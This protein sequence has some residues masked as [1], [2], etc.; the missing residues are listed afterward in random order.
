MT[1]LVFRIS[2]TILALSLSQV[3]FAEGS[4]PIKPITMIVGFAAGGPTDQAARIVAQ[5]MESVLQKPIVIENKPGANSTLS[6][7]ALQAS[8]PDGYTILIASNGILTV[9]GARYKNI[10]FDVSKDL[11][12]IG[13]VAGY[14]HVLV[15][16]ENSK[17]NDVKSII[18]SADV[19]YPAISSVGNVDELTIALFQN[20]TNKK[21]NSIPYKGQAAVIPDLI[22]N[23]VNMAFLAPNVAK[24]LVDAGKLKAIAVSGT[25]RVKSFP[26]TPTMDESGVKGFDVE[27]WNALV[28]KPGTPIEVLEKLNSSLK[29]SVANQEIREKLSRSGFITYPAETD[30]LIEKI[31]SEGS[32]WKKLIKSSDIPLIEF[33]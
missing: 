19:D 16:P 3:A 1:K 14:S 25:Q 31:E 32:K 24:P 18:D 17:Y 30:F 33:N 20:L 28:A 15:V 5:G 23:R 27:I 11:V 2:A 26:D 9:A 4:Y 7:N 21:L 13:L 12:P 10:P 6:I 8:K 29:D 22:A